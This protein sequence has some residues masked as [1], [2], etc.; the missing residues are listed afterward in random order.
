MRTLVK[1]TLIAATVLTVGVAIQQYYRVT[2]KL[3]D[4]LGGHINDFDRWMIMTPQFIHEG[5]GYVDDRLPTPPIMLMV[6]A[7]FT[8][9]SRPLAQFVWV[10]VKLP[11]AS[12]VLLCAI[13]IVRRS[14]G[15]L[16]P[17]ALMLIVAGWWLPVVLDMQEGQTNF[18]ALLPLVAGLYVAQEGSAVFDALAGLLIGLAIA[19]KVTPVIFALYFLWKGRWRVTLAAAAS[20]AIWSLVVPG[21]VFG[22][23]RN[24]RW[25]GEWVQI[26]IVPYVTKGLVVFAM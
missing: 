11:M 6:L 26:M 13:G 23:D 20:V 3:Q 5:A 8:A 12:L 19:I 22:F 25:F 14:G 4:P 16:T 9:L 10:C 1:W 7:P 17:Q 15:R 21:L 2:L 24:L 18:L